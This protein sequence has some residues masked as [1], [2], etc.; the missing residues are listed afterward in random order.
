MFTISEKLQQQ[1]IFLRCKCSGIWRCV[2]GR[3][4]PSVSKDIIVVIFRIKQS[5]FSSGSWFAWQSFEVVRPATQRDLP[6][7]LN[8]RQHRCE[9]FRS[10]KMYYYY[11][12]SNFCVTNPCYVHRFKA[13]FLICVWIFPTCLSPLLLYARKNADV[14][15]ALSCM[16]CPSQL[17]LLY[18]YHIISLKSV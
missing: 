9:N 8:L 6:E 15:S 16:L 3:A 14:G 13:D 17:A 4:V 10:H 1:K 12:Y 18:F 2:F 7:D 11:Y 5:K